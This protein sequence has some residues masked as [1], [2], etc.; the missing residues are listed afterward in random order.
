MPPETLAPPLRLAVSDDAEALASL[1]NAAYRGTD[2]SWT[3]ER[4]LVR[5]PRI[6][7]AEVGQRI[8]APASAILVA[9]R[10]DGRI[11]GCVHVEPRADVGYIGL[12][13]VDPA[14]QGSKTGSRLMQGAEAH[15]RDTLGR[16][17]AIVWVID[18]RP[19]LRAWY[20]RLG[21]VA[22]GETLPF[23]EDEALAPAMSFVVL[24]KAL[25]TGAR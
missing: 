9:T 18:A 24:R 22:T 3:H 12:L 7:V 14:S 4:G 21:Y 15:V 16:A 25:G 5:G 17:H 10:S 8:T 1:V 19:E 20:E 23:P 6:T 2:E 13:S 11:V